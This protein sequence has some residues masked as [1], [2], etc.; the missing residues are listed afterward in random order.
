MEEIKIQPTNID[1][2]EAVLGACILEN[3]AIFN[4]IDTSMPEM[5]SKGEYQIIFR[6]LVSM[7]HIMN[8]GEVSKIINKIN[9][10]KGL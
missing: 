2:E 3:N 1:A 5:F 10:K 8:V 9:I 6:S 4:I 7:F